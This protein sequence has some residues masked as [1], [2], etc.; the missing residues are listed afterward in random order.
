[1]SATAPVGRVD[2]TTAQYTTLHHNKGLADLQLKV[3]APLAVK[4]VRI[5]IIVG[6]SF[7]AT[8]LLTSPSAA[9]EWWFVGASSGTVRYADRSSI[10]PTYVDGRSVFQMWQYQRDIKPT[11]VGG[12]VSKMLSYFDCS[13]LRIANDTIMI[14]DEKGEVFKSGSLATNPPDWE[15]AAPDTLGDATARFAC[16][17]KSATGRAYSVDGLNY[18]RVDNVEADA[19]ARTLGR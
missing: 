14:L 2:S 17:G 3:F 13:T 16:H 11:P 18:Y 4:S 5:G 12:Y 15:P 6:L 7:L 8:A 19:K 9:S 1:M 10:M